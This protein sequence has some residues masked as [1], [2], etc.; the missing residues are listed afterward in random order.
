[1]L[2]NICILPGLESEY[3]DAGIQ[4]CDTGAIEERG[5]LL[6]SF[7]KHDGC[8]RADAQALKERVL[9]AQGDKEESFSF[10]RD[11]NILTISERG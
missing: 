4:G 1:L 7:P 5:T 2:K 6:V 9:K 10:D 3:E 11:L 8:F